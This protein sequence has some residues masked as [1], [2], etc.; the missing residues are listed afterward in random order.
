MEENVS[1]KIK[2]SSSCTPLTTKF[3]ML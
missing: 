3:N 1:K 2:F